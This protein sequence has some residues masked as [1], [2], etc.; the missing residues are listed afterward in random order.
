MSL[1]RFFKYFAL[2]LCVFAPLFIVGHLS[3]GVAFGLILV[4]CGAL[5]GSLFLG[6]QFMFGKLKNED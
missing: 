2:G 6:L 4:A 1:W 5:F 3:S